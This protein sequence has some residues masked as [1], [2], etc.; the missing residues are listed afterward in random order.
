MRRALLNSVLAALTVSLLAGCNIAAPAYFIIAGPPKRDA[1]FDLEQE[2]PTLVFVDDRANIAPRRAL[3]TMSAR[4]ATQ[5]LLDQ[6]ELNDAI[7][8]TPAYRVA[9]Q[10]ELAT[11]Q[12]IEAIGTAVGA[13]VVL[14]AILDTFDL[15]GATDSS[16][17]TAVARVK[18]LD[19]ETRQ[20]VWPGTPTGFPIRVVLPKPPN[21]GLTGRTDQVELENALA[22]QLGVGIAQ[23]FY[24]HEYT[25]SV[26]DRR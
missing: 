12:P 20:N 13:D 3:R 19:L 22:Q 23:L 5:V 21:F 4:A 7:D 9:S 15:R 1:S 10:D 11:P 8:P 2:R 17:P 16:G 6:G 26:I 14:Y 24:T 25:T 18:V